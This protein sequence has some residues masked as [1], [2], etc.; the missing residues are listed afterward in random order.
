MIL[1]SKYKLNVI[2]YEVVQIRIENETIEWVHDIKYLGFVIDEC[3]T[4]KCILRIY[5]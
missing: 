5:S 4:L 3:L 2:N 1:G